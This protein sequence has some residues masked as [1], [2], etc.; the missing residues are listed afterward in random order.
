MNFTKK[1]ILSLLIFCL[2]IS[3]VITQENTENNISARI[4]Y[5]SPN[6]D[7]VQDEL[8]VPLDIKDKRYI[9][10]WSFVITDKNGNILRTIGNKHKRA[11]TATDVFKNLFSGEG[12][13]G[14]FDNVG[15]TFA[16]K[17]GVEVPNEVRWNG[18]FETGEI[19][20]DGTYFYYLTASDD[21]GNKSQTKTYQVV[22]YV[23][24]GDK[25]KKITK[26]K[27]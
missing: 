6:N 12:I 5:I 2:S 3:F 20:P 4:D 9:S 23:K 14:F 10:E 16:P 11:D 19:A 13:K 27:M 17:S 15:K 1:L 21:N 8:V 7:G 25:L 18:V 22:V 24:N 26:T